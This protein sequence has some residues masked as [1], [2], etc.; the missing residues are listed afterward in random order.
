MTTENLTKAWEEAKREAKWNKVKEE[1]Y[2]KLQLGLAGEQY[3]RI[4]FSNFFDSE[5][6]VKTIR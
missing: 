1:F 6:K 4:S 5:G 2:L 3:D